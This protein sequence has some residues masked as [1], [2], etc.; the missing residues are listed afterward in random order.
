MALFSL[1]F[2]H[3]LLGRVGW[4][5]VVRS[6]IRELSYSSVGNVQKVLVKVRERDNVK[7]PVWEKNKFD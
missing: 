1:L 5:K 2:C 3:E 4:C 6:E 7:E